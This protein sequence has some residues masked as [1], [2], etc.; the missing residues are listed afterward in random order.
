MTLPENI[1][2]F[3]HFLLGTAMGIML[4]SL[5]RQATAAM[6]RTPW[7]WAAGTGFLIAWLSQ[8]LPQVAM[9]QP[10]SQGMLPAQYL[11][12]VIAQVIASLYMYL[13][14]RLAPRPQSPVSVVLSRPVLPRRE[15]HLV[16]LTSENEWSLPGDR[17]RDHGNHLRLVA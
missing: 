3:S 6:R 8:S 14:R 1:Q 15:H 13:S 7:L 11:G 16:L 9:G 12:V 2:F 5:C 10:L 4:W 17:G